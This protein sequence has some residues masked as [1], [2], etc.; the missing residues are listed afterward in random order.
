[1]GG[2]AAA[3]YS[4][5]MRR[6]AGIAL[7]LVGATLLL[8][9]AVLLYLVYVRPLPYAIGAFL[10]ACAVIALAVFALRRAARML[11]LSLPAIAGATVVWVPS[12]SCSHT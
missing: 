5:H 11:G 9:V 3:R 1:M 6:T 12:R 8:L 4:A 2:R 7:L 10:F